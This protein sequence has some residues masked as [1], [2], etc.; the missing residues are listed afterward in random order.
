ME[1]LTI[2][3]MEETAVMVD[4]VTKGVKVMMTRLEV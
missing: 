4:M 1:I 3:T 2:H